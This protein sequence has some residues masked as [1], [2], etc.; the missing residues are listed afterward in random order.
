MALTEALE[1]VLRDAGAA[2][3]GFGDM[4]GVENCSYPVG[5]SVAIPIP[6]PIIEGITEGPTKEYSDT[7]YAMN[8]KLNEI[9]TQGANFLKE[10]GY[11]AFAQTTDVVKEDSN[12]RTKI[13][14]KT[15]A[16]RAGLG[17]IGKSCLLITP[18]FGGAVRISS[19]LTDA[20]LQLHEPI[21]HSKCGN[22]QI[23]KEACPAQALKGV[24]WHL[25][26]KREELFEKEPCK[27]KAKELMKARAGF[28]QDICGKCFV[29]CPYTQKYLKK[30]SALS[31]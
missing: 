30:K 16:T 27:K 14:H 12:W 3:V 2:L 23:C 8:A 5:V 20:P 19:L 25:G 15:V 28:E 7:Y 31:E 22:C 10:Q 29:V 1:K 9:I 11:Q 26:M 21:N 4:Q 6:I 17:W 13:P 24:L 18:Q